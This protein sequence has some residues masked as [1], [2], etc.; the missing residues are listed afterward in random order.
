VCVVLHLEAEHS[1]SISAA[2][3]AQLGCVVITAKQRH[4]YHKVLATLNML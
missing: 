1:K 4:A 2:A 3:A